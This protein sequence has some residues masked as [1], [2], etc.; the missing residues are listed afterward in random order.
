M[1]ERVL[2]GAPGEAQPSTIVRTELAFA[3]SARTNGQWT[4]FEEF[5]A[6]GAMLHTRNGLRPFAVLRPALSDPEEAV[7]WAPRTVVMSC[8]GSHAVSVGR[9]QTPEGEVGTYVT[10]WERQSDNSYRWTYDGGA[11]DDP[12]PPARAEFEDGDIVVTAIDAVEGLI[13]SCPRGGAA[14]PPAPSDSAVGVRPADVK[15][16]RD[17][18]LRWRVE[19]LGEAKKYIAVEYFFEGRWVTAVEESLPAAP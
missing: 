16:S 13:A 6:P 19:H 17:G 2:T 1:I 3:R 4:A 14:I 11:L 9:L 12:Q 8:D 15:Q 18:T 10:I 5:A 7:Q